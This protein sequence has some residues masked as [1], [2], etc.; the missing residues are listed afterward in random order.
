MKLFEEGSS[1]R[2]PVQ[3]SPNPVISLRYNRI[4][5]DYKLFSSTDVMNIH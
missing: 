5:H 1:Y 4:R 2:S 3:I